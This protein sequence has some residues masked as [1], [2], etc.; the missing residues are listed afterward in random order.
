MMAFFGDAIPRLAMEQPDAPAIV[1]D[2]AVLDFAGFDRAVRARATALH[3][4]GLARGVA[5]G[6]MMRDTPELLVALFALQRLGAAVLLLSPTEPPALRNALL[7]QAGAR[8]VV[9]AGRDTGGHGVPYLALG[10]APGDATDLPPPDPDDLCMFRR[11]S[12]TTGGIPRLTPSSHGHEIMQFETLWGAVPWPVGNRYFSVIS[13][14]FEFGR[15]AAQHSLLGSGAVILPPPMQTI[16]DLVAAARRLGATWMSLTPTHLRHMLVPDA[17]QPLLPG[18]GIVTSSAVLTTAERDQVMKRISP[19]LFMLYATNEVGLLAYALPDDLRRV[20]E[21]VGRV[22]AS[23]QA[24]VVDGAGRSVGAGVVGELRFRHAAY[25]TRYAVADAGSPSRFADGWFYPGD[26]GVIDG[27]GL[28]FLKG[29]TDDVINVGGQK[30][31]PTDIEEC[32]TAHH[33]V[34]EAAVA[35]LPA[36]RL[37]MAPVAAVVLRDD[38]P[39]RDLVAHC[40]ARLGRD[41]APLEI[42][43]LDA[44]PKTAAG[45][46]DRRILTETLRALVIGRH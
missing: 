23:V 31:Y 36:R 1:T 41:R 16:A 8:L 21:S 4:H 24:D 45:K 26:V 2:D 9:G 28:V 37:G 10:D 30:V 27:D 43:V 20:A 6:L 22:P 46:I 11:S 35:G 25:P 12:G 7:D 44:L 19:D 14:A 13:T 18:V 29:R 40:V 39:G 15:Q 34:R 32:L 42:F 38:V 33:A 5:V 3:R 17:A